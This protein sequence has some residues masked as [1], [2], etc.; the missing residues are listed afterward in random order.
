MEQEI[1]NLSAL[2]P[3]REILEQIE[4]LKTC[5]KDINSEASHYITEYASR[6][7]IDLIAFQ[8]ERN[9]RRAQ[10]L[11]PDQSLGI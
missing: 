10:L 2:T 9:N 1:S 8:Q 4:L 6:G 7:E 5:I 11:N 3:T